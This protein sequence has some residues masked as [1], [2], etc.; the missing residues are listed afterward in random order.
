MITERYRGIR[1]LV[2]A[3]ATNNEL[4]ILE[5]TIDRIIDLTE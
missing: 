4:A 5:D 3:N 2:V 1:L